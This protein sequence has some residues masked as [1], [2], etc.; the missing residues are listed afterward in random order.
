MGAEHLNVLLVQTETKI[1]VP[2]KSEIVEVKEGVESL[3]FNYCKLIFHKKS[4]H[5]TEATVQ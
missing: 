3:I 1:N 2:K 5:T 4:T